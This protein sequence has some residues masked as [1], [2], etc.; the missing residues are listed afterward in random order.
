MVTVALLA[1][2]CG[3]GRRLPAPAL[4]PMAVAWRVSLPETVEGPLATDGER[5]FVATRDGSVRA[6]DR[7][8]GAVAWEVAKRPGW[9]GY[10]EGLLAVREAD[11]TV[12][13]LDPRTGSARW[14]AQS[15]VTGDLPP[16]IYKDAVLVGGQGLASLRADSGAGVWTVKEPRLTVPPVASGAWI[17]VGEASGTLRN[18]DLAS[19]NALWGFLTAGS[20]RAEPVVDDR[21]RALLGTTDRRFL[22]LDAASGKE[23]WTW[24]LGADLAFPPALLGDKVLFATHEDVLYALRR[25]NGH[26]AWRAPLPSRPL[27]GPLLYGSGV[28]LACHG[29][30][31]GETFLLGFD[32]MTGRRQGD[33]K[34][35]GEIAS[36]PVLVGDRVY[37]ALREKAVAALSLGTAS[38]PEPAPSTPPAR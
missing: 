19:G 3:G 37:L 23:R 26:L 15:G 11:G 8:T 1:A 35:P 18:R 17:L 12:W 14:K 30:R 6:L 25:G 38:A 27:S 29:S 5:I 24:K 4:F 13:G 2:A 22:A 9:L 7:L 28:L 34:S 33:L 16:V 10:G 20:L 31:P 32:G 36:P 21:G